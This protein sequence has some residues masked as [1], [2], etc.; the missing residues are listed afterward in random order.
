MGK[1]MRP[2]ADLEMKPQVRSEEQAK[3]M[4]S[5]CLDDKGKTL[6]ITLNHIPNKPRVETPHKIILCIELRLRKRAR[7]N[8]KARHS[9]QTYRLTAE[10]CCDKRKYNC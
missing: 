3:C 9:Y 6:N 2:N 5:E 7:S 8:W 10:R 1:T 4:Y